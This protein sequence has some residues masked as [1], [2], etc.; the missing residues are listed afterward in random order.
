MPNKVALDL[1]G[2]RQRPFLQNH[3]WTDVKQ[4]LSLDMLECGSEDDKAI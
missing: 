4:D 3:E 1:L 2:F